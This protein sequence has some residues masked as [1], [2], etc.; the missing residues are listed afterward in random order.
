[1][2]QNIRLF[3]FISYIVVQSRCQGCDTTFSDRVST[4][5]AT[6]HDGY[7]VT[8][9]RLYNG[10]YKSVIT[11]PDDIRIMFGNRPNPPQHIATC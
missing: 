8:D 5:P 11:Y 1:M 2:R 10:Q 7:P 3:V 9:L 4:S 6:S